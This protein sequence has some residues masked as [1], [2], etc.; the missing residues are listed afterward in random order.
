MSYDQQRHQ[1]GEH[2][3]PADLIAATRNHYFYG[4]LLD[5]FHLEMEQEYFNNKRWLLN[6]LVTGPGVVCGLRVELT[7]DDVVVMPGL[8]IDRCGREIIVASPSKPQPLP[9]LPDYERGMTK[10]GY[11]G[12]GQPYRGSR[13]RDDY[14]GHNYCERPFKHVVLCYHECETDPVPAMAGDCETTTMCASGSIRERYEIQFKDGFATPRQSNFPRNAIENGKIN[15]DAIVN[16]VTNGCRA[17]PEDCCLPLANIEL[18]ESEDGWKPEIDN[19]IRP[20][21]YTNRLLFDLIKS[22]VRQEDTE[23]SEV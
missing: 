18:R 8:A 14:E 17:F 12:S 3:V 23:D 1:R 21:V 13:A 19:S 16:Y 15:Y 10:Q 4:K 11:Q 22:L 2:K 9:P 7:D 20:I 6:R 5:V